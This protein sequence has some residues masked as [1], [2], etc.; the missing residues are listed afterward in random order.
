M[1]ALTDMIL[2]GVLCEFCGVYIGD[3]VSYPRKCK[4]CQRA[5]K[6][7]FSAELGEIAKDVEIAALRGKITQLESIINEIRAWLKSGAILT[8][9]DPSGKLLEFDDNG[10]FISNIIGEISIPRK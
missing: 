2:E 1:G 10:E 4:E 8:A 6:E 3:E 9:K 5:E 7:A